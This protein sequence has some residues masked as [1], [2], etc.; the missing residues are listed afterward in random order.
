MTKTALFVNILSIE[1]IAMA[2]SFLT[3]AYGLIKTSLVHSTVQDY[4]NAVRPQ[5]VP[6]LLLGL[7]M[8][9][10]GFYGMLVWPLPSSCNILFYDLYSVLGLGIIGIALSVKNEY[11][12]EH[13]G[14]M[15]LLFGFVTIYYG[16]EGYLHNMTNEP[17]ALLALY[18]LTGL[19]AVFF[20]PSLCS[21][22]TE[23]SVRPD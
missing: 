11:K 7:L 6:Q 2:V 20:Y 22:T 4:R 14:F 1:L 23:G 17:L 12:L 9:V 13:L 18:A 19:A 21:W 10:S 15:S 5:Y 3:L 16:V 8:A